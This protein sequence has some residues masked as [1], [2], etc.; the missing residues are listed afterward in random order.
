[1]LAP[2]DGLAVSPPDKGP[3]DGA[4][5]GVSA[6]LATGRSR[7]PP[8][9]PAAQARP[10]PSP[11]GARWTRARAMPR[12]PATRVLARPATFQP[13][14]GQQ[15]RHRHR[16]AAPSA[17]AGQALGPLGEGDRRA[18]WPQAAEPLYPKAISTARPS[19]ALV[20]RRGDVNLEHKADGFRNYLGEGK[21]A[22]D[23]VFLPRQGEPAYPERTRV[24]SPRRRTA[25]EPRPL[26]PHTIKTDRPATA[27][28]VVLSRPLG[29]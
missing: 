27:G 6:C 2:R 5:D 14:L 18:L 23:R 24:D 19:A 21:P 22:A 3:F 20:D 7:A 26:R 9:P 8:A 16:D 13:E 17:A 4:G 29:S 11:G 15:H 1:M 25:R 12:S 28:M 10:G